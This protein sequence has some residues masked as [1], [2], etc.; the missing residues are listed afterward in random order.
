MKFLCLC[1]YCIPQRYACPTMCCIRNPFPAMTFQ[2]FNAAAILTYI[3]V[4]TIMLLSHNLI[5]TKFHYCNSSGKSGDSQ[6]I[7][8][9]QTNSRI[10]SQGMQRKEGH[11]HVCPESSMNEML[12][13]PKV[14]KRLGFEGRQRQG[15]S[16]SSC[17]TGCRH[18]SHYTKGEF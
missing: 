3:D 14:R 7:L 6:L 5:H 12:K 15:R 2:T 9:R 16:M 13:I 11:N 10:I 4:I 18:T 8:C 1:F 17:P